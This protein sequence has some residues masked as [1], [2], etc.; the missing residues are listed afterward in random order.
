M[1]ESKK[2]QKVMNLSKNTEVPFLINLTVLSKLE[3][4]KKLSMTN[5]WDHIAVLTIWL[6]QIIL[7]TTLSFHLGDSMRIMAGDRSEKEF[8][9]PISNRTNPVNISLISSV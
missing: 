5:S 4:G 9:D 3:M 6:S 1:T 7:Q 8:C 2:A